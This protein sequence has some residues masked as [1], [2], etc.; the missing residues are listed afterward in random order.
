M[1]WHQT[2]GAEGEI[3]LTGNLLEGFL[4]PARDAAGAEIGD[5]FADAESEKIGAA[6]GV[7]LLW[8]A[9]GF[10]ETL[11]GGGGHWRLPVGE[12]TV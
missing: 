9:D 5:T 4:E 11:G 12:H 3:S 7:V 8:E 10:V 1:I 2:V 6:A